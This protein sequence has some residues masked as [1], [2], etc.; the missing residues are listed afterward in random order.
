MINQVFWPP[1]LFKIM[2]NKNHQ[3]KKNSIN[4]QNTIKLIKRISTSKNKK[5]SYCKKISFNSNSSS[6][7]LFGCCC[8][9][10][11]KKSTTSLKMVTCAS[12]TTISSN[13]TFLIWRKIR[14]ACLRLFDAG[15]TSSIFFSCFKMQIFG[16]LQSLNKDILHFDCF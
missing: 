7:P 16:N 13:I 12:N 6:L 2:Q 9:K 4:I 14:C 10:I 1:C 8:E 5:V 3:N 15:K 11:V